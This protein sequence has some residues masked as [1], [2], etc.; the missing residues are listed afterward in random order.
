M[1]KLRAELLKLT[2]GVGTS[3]LSAT[4]PLSMTK[5]ESATPASPSATARP[6]FRTS[7]PDASTSPIQMA[8]VISTAPVN[9]GIARDWAG[10]IALLTQSKDKLGIAKAFAILLNIGEAAELETLVRFEKNIDGAA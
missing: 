4:P 8:N 9:E 5:A 1:E 2:A 6:D 7:V 10:R 3:V